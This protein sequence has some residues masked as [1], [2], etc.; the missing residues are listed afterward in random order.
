VDE[1]LK[2]LVN[3]VNTGSALAYPAMIG[4]FIIKAGD[5][6]VWPVSLFI[7]GRAIILGIKT[8]ME[9]DIKT[10]ETESR[11]YSNCPHNQ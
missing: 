2:A 10:R 1:L 5:I 4:F 11:R 8:C 3:L 9:L 7:V 6:L